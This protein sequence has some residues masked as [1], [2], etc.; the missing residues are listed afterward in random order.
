MA[1]SYLREKA[2]RW[3]LEHEEE[4]AGDNGMAGSF[5]SQEA[6]REEAGIIW[7]YG[8]MELIKRLAGASKDIGWIHVEQ[9]LGLLERRWENRCLCHTDSAQSGSIQAFFSAG[10]KD[11]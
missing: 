10:K 7:S 9:V 4:K 8:I 11:L 1:D 3:L 5:L 2:F 6:F